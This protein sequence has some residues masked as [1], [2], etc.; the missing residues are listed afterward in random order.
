MVKH[1]TV[2]ATYNCLF[3][4]GILLLRIVYAIFIPKQILYVSYNHVKYSLDISER[5]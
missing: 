3:A 2:P 5:L 1:E 4:A